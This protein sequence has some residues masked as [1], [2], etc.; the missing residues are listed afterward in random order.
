MLFIVPGEQY[1]RIEAFAGNKQSQLLQEVKRALLVTFPRTDLRADGQVV[2]APFETYD[3]DIVPAFRFASGPNAGSYLTA[4][5]ADGGS[6]RLSNP[7]AEYRWI[8]SVD[9]ATLG[10]ATILMKMLKA[11]KRECNVEIK[12]VCLEIAAGVFVNQWEHRGKGVAYYG[13]MVRDFFGFMLEYVNGRTRP[14]GIQEWIPLGDSWQSKCQ[15]AYSH[16][17]KACEY[18]YLDNPVSATSEWQKIFG[19]Q[20]EIDWLSGLLS[21]IGA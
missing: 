5:T 19:S 13:W 16:A 14:A 18:E 20:F 15:T 21:G 3:V 2:V 12:S 9:A 10:K 8:T 6:W 17:A 7:L 1:N 11:W 4:H